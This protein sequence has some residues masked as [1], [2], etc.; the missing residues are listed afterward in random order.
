RAVAPLTRLLRGE[1]MDQLALESRAIKAGE[2]RA[3]QP[4]HGLA[5]DW[6]KLL[7]PTATDDTFA[8]GYAQTV[9]FALL[10]ARTEGITLAGPGGLHSVGTKLAGEHSL[11]ARAL[12]LLTDYVA[13]DF[14]VT[15][16]LMV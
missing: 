16:D 7:F 13:E 4:F 8:D 11:M 1:V 10:L 3:S 5:R 2:D 12:Q 6:R 14:K 15:I 9:A